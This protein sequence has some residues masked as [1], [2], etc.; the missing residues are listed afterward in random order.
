MMR[1]VV[2]TRDNVQRLAE[3]ARSLVESGID[4]SSVLIVDDSPS[5]ISIARNRLAVERAFERTPQILSRRRHEEILSCLPA[6]ARRCLGGYFELGKPG[7]NTYAARNVGLLWTA[8]RLGGRRRLWLDDDV[9]VSLNVVR[10]ASKTP[11]GCISAFPL[12][13]LPDFSRTRWIS[14]FLSCI[15]AATPIEEA[16]PRAA[17]LLAH[18]DLDVPIDASPVPAG[19]FPLPWNAA[20]GAAFA[21]NIAL[22]STPLYPPFR[23]EDYFWHRRLLDLGV[24]RVR[25]GASVKHLGR[26]RELLSAPLFVGEELGAIQ[27]TCLRLVLANP[28][29]N[30]RKTLVTL[31]A[32]RCRE[33]GVLSSTAARMVAASACGQAARR[34][35][36]LL[37]GVKEV[38]SSRQVSENATEQVAVSLHANAAWLRAGTSRMARPA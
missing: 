18:T 17:L 36:D 19:P 7:W 16:A 23:G 1:I 30:V 3:T 20:H 5:D 33:L 12:V 25:C 22:G 27:A 15:D 29:L 6:E 4:G 8:R 34:V 38:L 32:R 2:V 9:E 26:R 28:N 11:R 13:G 24:R 35:V 14:I 31:T 37:D 21:T 10:L